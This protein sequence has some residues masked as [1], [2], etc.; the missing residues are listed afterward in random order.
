MWWLFGSP[1]RIDAKVKIGRW[2]DIEVEDDVTAV[3]EYPNGATGVFVTTTG[4]APGT[5]RL[6]AVGTRGKVVM[7]GSAGPVQFT[8]NE[9]P[10]DE[11][12]RTTDKGFSKPPVW[13]IE[14]PTTGNGGQHAEVMQNFVDACA[15]TAEL[16]APAGE[17]I[18]SVEL[19]NAMLLSG[20]TKKAVDLPID[21]KVFERRL[22]KLIKESTFEKKVDAK[23]ASSSDFA[24]SF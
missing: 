9:V 4:E 21:G 23:T 12:C 10:M 15:G 18:Y 2:H 6:E 20:L 19:A 11:W 8:R 3:L 14:I 5:N 22:K 16:I 1:S 13:N 24:K 17:G 7:D